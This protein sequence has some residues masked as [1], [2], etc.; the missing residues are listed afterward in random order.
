[1]ADVCHQ[2][3]SDALNAFVEGN[4]TL[5][6]KLA[7]QDDEI[8]HSYRKVVEELFALGSEKPEVITQAVSLAFVGHHLERIGDH[9]T[10]IGESVIY[11]VSGER[12]D[13]N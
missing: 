10:N 6:Q 1:M 12:S 4:I 9:A 8:D 7:E 3:V 5:A 11:I 13:L 2:M